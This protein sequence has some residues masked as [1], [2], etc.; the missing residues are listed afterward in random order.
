[1]KTALETLTYHFGVINDEGDRRALL[2]AMESFASQYKQEPK[3][4]HIDF[5]PEMEETLEVLAK[6]EGVS[7]SEYCRS[8]VR[9]VV[10]SPPTKVSVEEVIEE[11][12]RRL[13]NK[14]FERFAHDLPSMGSKEMVLAL[15]IFTGNCMHAYHRLN[16]QGEGKWVDPKTTPPT[17]K[18]K[19]VYLVKHKKRFRG[20]GEITLAGFSSMGAGIWPDA[21]GYV[22]LESILPSPPNT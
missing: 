21:I 20:D 1:M 8:I 7:F 2:D 13:G 10:M 19:A 18:K 6:K 22:L 11:I 9:D 16:S 5:S 14:S 3:G 15:H 4:R 17:E 12:A